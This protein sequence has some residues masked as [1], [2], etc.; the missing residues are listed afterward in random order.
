MQQIE[1]RGVARLAM[2]PMLTEIPHLGHFS[3][4]FVYF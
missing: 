1:K 4:D 2:S 3:T